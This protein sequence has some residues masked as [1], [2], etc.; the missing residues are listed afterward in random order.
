MLLVALAGIWHKIKF[1]VLALDDAAF[2]LLLESRHYLVEV[3]LVGS[4]HIDQLADVSVERLIH[5]ACD[6]WTRH[7]IVY[8]VEDHGDIDA[9]GNIVLL[10]KSSL[11]H[12]LHDWILRIK[13]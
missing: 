9:S 5:C 10:L 13:N 2:L 11:Q 8:L 6:G 1:H 4:E 7:W 12:L 3:L